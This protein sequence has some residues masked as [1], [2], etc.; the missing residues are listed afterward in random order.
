MKIIEFLKLKKINFFY[1][2]EIKKIIFL[3]IKENDF[4]NFKS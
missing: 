1:S 3:E 2:F 4:L